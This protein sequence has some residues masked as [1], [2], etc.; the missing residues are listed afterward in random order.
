MNETTQTC[1]RC[2]RK[3]IIDTSRVLTTNPPKYLGKCEECDY[4]EYF[5]NPYANIVDRNVCNHDFDLKLINGEYITYCKKCG[6]IG[7]KVGGF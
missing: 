5:N 3:M 4:R 2:G 7:E 6:K 1:P